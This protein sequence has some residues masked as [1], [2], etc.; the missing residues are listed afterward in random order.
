MLN[1]AHALPK[2]R[3]VWFAVALVAMLG[4]W[5][6]FRPELLFIN[7]KV[8][9]APPAQAAGQPIPLFTGQFHGDVHKTSGRATIYQLAKESRVVTLTNFSTSSGPALHVILLDG[10]GVS[11][12][13][14]FTLSD[15]KNQDLG[16]LK[17]NQG[18]Q[19]YALP[20]SVD[21]KRF[22]TVAIYCVRFTPPS[23]LQS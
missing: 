3:I 9:E 20:A 13:S 4:L 19:N 16:E 5:Y 6:A 14:D 2:K 15:V 11:T 7:K 1:P 22:N 23:V 10:S 12:E 8:D 21:L 18:D 17:G